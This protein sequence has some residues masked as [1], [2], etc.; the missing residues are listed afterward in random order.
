[1]KTE[2]PLLK[3]KQELISMF[4]SLDAWFDRLLDEGYNREE[5]TDLLEVVEHILTSNFSILNVLPKECGNDSQVVH[6][7]FELTTHL[8]F[9]EMRFALRDQ[10][11]QS[12]CLLDVL[13]ESMNVNAIDRA[14]QMDLHDKL[15]SIA[16]HLR[17]H[18]ELLQFSQSFE[19]DHCG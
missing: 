3:I 17:Y 15:F 4:A 2:S 11:Y 6:H 18:L 12:L 5:E 8:S 19:K 13:D 14:K 7:E 9:E 10:L 16:Q 1:M